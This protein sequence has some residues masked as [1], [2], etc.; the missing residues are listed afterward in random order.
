MFTLTID[1]LLSIYHDQ[2]GRCHW[3]GT[4]TMSLHPNSSWQMS[5][6]RLNPERGYVM[7]NCVLCCLEFN[8]SRTWTWTKIR[9]MID[10][11]SRP[12]QLDAEALLNSLRVF[13]IGKNRKCTHRNP[14]KY[15]CGRCIPCHKT[16]QA[17]LR[18]GAVKPIDRKVCSHGPEREVY[19]DGKCKM[20]TKEKND[21]R[22]RH[23]YGFLYRVLAHMNEHSAFRGHTAPEFQSVHEIARRIVDQGGRCHISCLPMAMVANTEFATSPERLGA[24]AHYSLQNTVFIC[25]EFNSFCNRKGRQSKDKE[26]KDKVD[27]Q[28]TKEKADEWFAWLESEEGRARIERGVL[29]EEKRARALQ[30]EGSTSETALLSATSS[31]ASS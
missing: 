12:F 5:L 23:P 20:C 7:D 22:F 14:E 16:Y 19:K 24:N 2:E 27:S 9:R 18:R 11:R 30:L 13:E 4:K 3:F 25:A 15:K 29:E 10:V 1:Q 26:M 17:D 28:W 6:D 31:A 8:V 21:E